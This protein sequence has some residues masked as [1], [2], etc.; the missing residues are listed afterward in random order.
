MAEESDDDTNGDRPE[1]AEPTDNPSDPDDAPDAS[2]TS[3]TS[4]ES[5][6][7]DASNTSDATEGEEGVDE[8]PEDPPVATDDDFNTLHADDAND[9]DDADDSVVGADEDAASDSDEEPPDLNEAYGLSGDSPETPP[10]RS[11]H[12]PD[13]AGP[14]EEAPVDAA[15]ADAPASDGGYADDYDGFDDYDS[16]GAASPTVEGAPDDQEMPLADHIE[17]MVKRLGVVIVVMAVISGLVFPYGADLINFLWYSYLPGTVGQ[18]PEAAVKVTEIEGGGAACPRVYHPLALILARL[19]VATLAGFIVA[20]PVFVYETYLFMR[21]GL[22]LTERRYYLASV[23]TSLLLA[24]VGVA[25]A[26]FLV[27]PAI[28]TYFVYYSENATVIAFGL[29]ETFDL[30]VLLMGGFAIIFQI[31]LF[32]MLALM[33]GL[34]TRQWMTDRRLIFW[35]VFAGLA[36]LFSP[37]PTGMAPIIVAATMIILFE[38]TLLLAKWTGK[39]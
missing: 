22:Y 1:R 23:P 10:A 33:M 14:D 29:T 2:D 27:I 37:D 7:S 25:F 31:P 18:C 32:I 20:L 12:A 11:D 21:P 16:G 13:A 26:H 8:E 38:S 3:D 17:E 5:E 6:A 28:F 34:V 39:E 9:S 35:G 19:K 24:S 30:M 15:A 36:F 4:D